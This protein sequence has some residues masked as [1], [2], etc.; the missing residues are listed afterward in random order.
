MPFTF[1]AISPR[2]R[3]HSLTECGSNL[4]RN[5]TR[6]GADDAARAAQREQAAGQALGVFCQSLLAS[7]QFLY[8]D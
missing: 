3:K 6:R 8:I 5:A 4:G 1:G 2:L 7:N